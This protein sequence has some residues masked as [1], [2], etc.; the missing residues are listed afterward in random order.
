MLG[1]SDHKYLEFQLNQ[2]ISSLEVKVIEIGDVFRDEESL[3]SDTLGETLSILFMSILQLPVNQETSL[4]YNVL[5]QL[6]HTD[7]VV[8]VLVKSSNQVQLYLSTSQFMVAVR[9]ISQLVQSVISGEIE[10]EDILRTEN[11]RISL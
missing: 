1:E 10:Q 7:N 9:I 11:E 4:K 2:E 8:K 6:L 5:V 3:D